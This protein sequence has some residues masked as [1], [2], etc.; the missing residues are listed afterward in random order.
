M[1]QFDYA[2]LAI[3]GVSMLVGVW[4][5]VV[6]E[7]LALVAWV[8]AFVAAQEFASTVVPWL[9]KW[10]SDPGLCLVAA[11]AGIFV[12]VLL[13]F[14]ILRLLVSLMLS[15]VGLALADRFL[16]ACFGALRG[17]LIVLV[18]VMLA[19]VT[20]IPEKNFWRDAVLAPPL[21]TVIIAGK[22]WMPVEMA[23]RVKFHR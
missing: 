16:G 2:V 3:I 23:S 6:S 1:T 14:A 8:A 5:G 20:S 18:V 11:Y 12:A 4:R 13:C 22:R 7:L 19:G 15:A 17:V 10:I 9:F 21:E